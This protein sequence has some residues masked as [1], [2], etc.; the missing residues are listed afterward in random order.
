MHSIVDQSIDSFTCLS[1]PFLGSSLP[2]FLSGTSLVQ[3]NFV[4]FVHVSL[5]LLV[6]P[7]LFP[8]CHWIISVTHVRISLLNVA[9]V[10]LFYIGGAFLYAMRIP[11]RFFPGKCDYWFQSHQIFH[12]FVI[13]AAIIHYVVIHDIASLKFVPKDASSIAGPIATSTHAWDNDHCDL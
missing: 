12:I 6:S 9:L 7:L 3:L 1:L 10:A 13:I 2:G 5:L 4:S 8:F 11:E